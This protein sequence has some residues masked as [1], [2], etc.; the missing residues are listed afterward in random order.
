MLRTSGRILESAKVLRNASKIAD[1]V[2]TLINPPMT[3]ECA[4]LAVE[5]LKSGLWECQS[6]GMDHLTTDP[7]VVSELLELANALESDTDEDEAREVGFTILL[8]C[9]VDP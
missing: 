6:F 1:A 9:D 8:R 7:E 4:Q 2:K 5:Y 3:Q